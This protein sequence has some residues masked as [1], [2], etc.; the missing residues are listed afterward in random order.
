[1]KKL[2]FLAF[3][4]FVLVGCGV[5]FSNVDLNTALPDNF[6]KRTLYPRTE[7]LRFK[8]PELAGSV[9]YQQGGT[10]TFERGAR[11][12]K[13]G[14]AAAL[15]SI[16]DDE[17]VV[18]TSKI[19]RGA[20]VQGSYLAFSAAFTEK[21]TADI[22]IRDTSLVFIVDADVPWDKLKAEALKPNPSPNTH[23]YWVQGALLAGITINNYAELA[24][25]ASGVVGETFGA[26]GN[27]YNK[28]GATQHDYSISLELVDLEKLAIVA[29][30]AIGL[31]E[32]P[33]DSKGSATLLKRIKAE[34]LK[35]EKIE[36]K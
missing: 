12:V 17:R 23:R 4:V 5:S 28:Q 35:I 6:K 27:V 36:W 3:P 29:R 22:D 11:I 21:Q 10:G 7:I 26:K 19:D 33:S 18:Y 32:L 14:Y 20:A 8:L 16:K 1:V 34:T 25:N 15:E 30:P 13:D 31:F 9:L 24:A 2:L